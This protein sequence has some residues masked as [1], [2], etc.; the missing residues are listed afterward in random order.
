MQIIRR[1]FYLGWN[2]G[3]IYKMHLELGRLHITW[4]YSD[5]EY[6]KRRPNTKKKKEI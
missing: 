2:H 5:K 3:F 1:G 4:Q 6:L